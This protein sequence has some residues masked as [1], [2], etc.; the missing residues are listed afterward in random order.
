MKRILCPVDLSERSIEP[1]KYAAAVQQW[2]GG[3]V[4]ILHVVPTFDAVEMHAGDW[5]DP[6]SVAYPMPRE[7]VIDC[8]RQAV[9]AAR[10]PEAHLTY[11]IE[12]GEPAAAIVNRALAL[13]ADVIVVGTHA[14]LGIDGLVLGSIADS[15]LR[16]AA[17]DVLT[18]PVDANDATRRIQMS[19]IVCGVDFSPWSLNALHA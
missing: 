10:I 2:Y 5:F 15:V 8:M 17:C 11:E 7:K 19:T 18:V 14:R 4:T 12:A 9:A 1:L 16:R 3:C 13:S 6:V